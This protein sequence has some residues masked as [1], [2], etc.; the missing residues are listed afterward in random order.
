MKK[1]IHPNYHKIKV[2]MTD[3]TNFETM[4]T[5]GKDGD[6]LQLDIDPKSHA[7]WTG[8]KQKVMDKGRVSRFNKRFKNLKTSKN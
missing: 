4:S 1:K 3:G 6:S 5:W 2:I 8:G 7:A